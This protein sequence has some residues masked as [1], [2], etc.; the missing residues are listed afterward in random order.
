MLSHGQKPAA[1]K[2]RV[3][4]VTRLIETTPAYI[5]CHYLPI[6]QLHYVWF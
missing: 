1:F 3:N 2:F 4:Y 5:I 6:A